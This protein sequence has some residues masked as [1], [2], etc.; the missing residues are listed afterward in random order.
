MGSHSVKLTQP[1]FRH[2]IP[3][4][5]DLIFHTPQA[6]VFHPFTIDLKQWLVQGAYPTDSRLISKADNVYK[7]QF[8]GGYVCTIQIMGQPAHGVATISE[9]KMGIDYIPKIAYRGPDAIAYRIV[10]VMGQ[11]SN[12]CCISLYV[13][14]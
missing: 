10:N 3:V 9:D 2:F 14:T 7:K 6:Q 8:Q 13:R 1:Y 12:V 5:Q 4:C 11:P